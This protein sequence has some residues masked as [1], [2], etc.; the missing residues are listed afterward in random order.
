M[1]QIM[2]KTANI[3]E[4]KIDYGPFVCLWKYRSICF[5]FFIRTHYEHTVTHRHHDWR[6]KL[7]HNSPTFNEAVVLYIW[8]Y[9]H[10]PAWHFGPVLPGGQTHVNLLIPSTHVEPKAQ[11]DDKHSLI[12]GKKVHISLLSIEWLDGPSHGAVTKMYRKC[13][14]YCVKSGG[15]LGGSGGLGSGGV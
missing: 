12:S 6:L 14:E 3:W 9:L 11:G 10:K 4:Y 7:H 1:V 5:F 2:K 15:S 13:T 8:C